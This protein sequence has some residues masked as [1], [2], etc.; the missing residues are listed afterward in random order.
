MCFFLTFLCWDIFCVCFL[1]GA[2]LRSGTAKWADIFWPPVS[3]RSGTPLKKYTR[4]PKYES[5][6]EWKLRMIYICCTTVDYSP[7]TCSLVK[8]HPYPTSWQK[9]GKE[10]TTASFSQDFLKVLKS[11]TRGPEHS[12]QGRWPQ[13]ASLSHLCSLW[14]LF[15][16]LYVL[17]SFFQWPCRLPAAPL[18]TLLRLLRFTLKFTKNANHGELWQR[19]FWWENGK[20]RADLTSNWGK[21]ARRSKWTVMRIF[22][23]IRNWLFNLLNVF[24]T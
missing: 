21:R 16:L 22:F 5:L 13:R 11:E 7:P 24:L 4:R 23:F 20:L 17:A 2:G 9:A 12:K 3:W 1:P 14:L 15:E 10:E 18:H 8:V 19:T 6:Q